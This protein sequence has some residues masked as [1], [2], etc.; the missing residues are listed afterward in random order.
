MT[1]SSLVSL[2][3]VASMGCSGEALALGHSL[4]GKPCTHSDRRCSGG[5]A[6]PS[7]LFSLF[8][9][10]PTD[11]Q[12]GAKTLVAD[13]GQPIT[14]INGGGRY[15]TKADG[16]LELAT[17]G[18]VC[19]DALGLVIEPTATN[20]VG[21]SDD[22]SSDWAPAGGTITGSCT[23][24]DGSSH[25][26]SVDFA[27]T[28]G[29]GDYEILYQSL[30]DLTV[31]KYSVGIYMQLTAGAPGHMCFN[32]TRGAVVFQGAC[33]VPDG[34]WQ[35][36]KAENWDGIADSWSFEVGTDTRGGNAFQT[37]AFTAC[38]WG[39]QLEKTP[40]L[41]S[42][43]HTV[44][45]PAT[46][47]PDSIY[48]T[49]IHTTSGFC[50]SATVQDVV[51]T[52]SST[53][54]PIFNLGDFVGGTP[55]TFSMAVAPGT[56][57]LKVSVLDD[58]GTAKVGTQTTGDSYA[59]GTSY[60]GCVSAAGAIT[61]S[62]NSSALTL[63]S[64]GTGTGIIPNPVAS[65]A[66]L[67]SSALDG[68]QVYGMHLKAIQLTGVAS[69]TSSAYFSSGPFVP[70]GIVEPWPLGS[71][72]QRFCVTAVKGPTAGS[73]VTDTQTRYHFQLGGQSAANSLSF[74]QVPSNS[75][76]SANYASIYYVDGGSAGSLTSN[77]GAP[78]GWAG[79]NVNPSEKIAI[80]LDNGT[81]YFYADG[82][83]T[84]TGSYGTGETWPATMVIG[85]TT[86]LSTDSLFGSALTSVCIDGPT[87]LTSGDPTQDIKNTCH[88]FDAPNPNPPWDLTTCYG[89]LNATPYADAGVVLTLGDSITQS[90]A[91]VPRV[92][93]A[94]LQQLIGQKYVVQ[95]ISSGGWTT[96]DIK[97]AYEATWNFSGSANT[98]AV[99]IG[100]GDIFAQGHTAA[101]AYATASA[102]FDEIRG[103]GCRLIVVTLTPAK[104]TGIG[105]TSGKQT[106]YDALRADYI[107][108]CG[109]HSSDTTCVDTYPTMG[110]GTTPPQLK[111]DFNGTA[112]SGDNTHPNQAG[113]DELANLVYSAVSWP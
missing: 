110:D 94:K 22:M 66:F 79:Y 87:G 34:T 84:V 92:Y 38:V 107:S 103:N 15:C 62:K 104:N 19:V 45:G 27:A 47:G 28:S 42:L 9:I 63:T 71:S 100:I 86:L 18:Q 10:G 81:Y 112:G 93:P 99:L 43:I 76:D 78:S 41:T 80:C 7:S 59:T 17:T 109:A 35:H 55:G 53:Y 73:W 13:T 16:G 46:R 72:A 6:S 70:Y 67:G 23:A 29:P 56:R 21:N 12:T 24:P 61:A 65:I 31:A 32:A 95:R 50:A 101:T 40:V 90:G 69:T 37:G 51:Q 108:Y 44:G 82:V 75:S 39:A 64:S 49:G 85:G 54:Q 4:R 98:C 74:Y 48:V 105:W 26:V 83:Q 96:T 36:L 57:K 102:L 88:Q 77:G 14:N 106:Q 111:D 113:S 30:P 3:A 1:R 33:V 52:T 91:V 68:G 89:C 58:A 8:A 60:Q 97:T 25:G 11:G 2:L 5:A 20:L